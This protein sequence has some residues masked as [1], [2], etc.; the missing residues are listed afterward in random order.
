[1][2][3]DKV[4]E[5]VGTECRRLLRA[6]LHRY[7]WKDTASQFPSGRGWISRML[8]HKKPLTSTQAFRILLLTLGEPTL[9]DPKVDNAPVP[10]PMTAW[11]RTQWAWLAGLIDGEGCISIQK[12]SDR[13][14]ERYRFSLIIEMSHQGTLER[15][16]KI[17]QAGAL[18]PRPIKDKEHHKPT[19]C[20]R[21]SEGP[22]R[23]VLINVM[24]W[25]ITKRAQAVLGLR[26]LA[27]TNKNSKT[28]S[29]NGRIPITPE[30][31]EIMR[32]FYRQS[33]VLN[34]RGPVHDVTKIAA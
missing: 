13:G 34:Q 15:A 21:I 28:N 20:W 24:P 5:E 30:I 12:K 4:P 25:L 14:Q 9:Q 11:E 16:Y 29:L 8:N 6:L 1:M 17:A 27:A 7:G 18:Y 10:L 32:D 2:R 22:A 31:L 23:R 26:Y 19:Y 3:E 33:H